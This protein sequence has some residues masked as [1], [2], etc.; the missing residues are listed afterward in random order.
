MEYRKY[1]LV[2]LFLLFLS[3]LVH[4]PIEVQKVIFKKVVIEEPVYVDVISEYRLIFVDPCRS[5]QQS[6]WYN[7][8]KLEKICNGEFV[9]AYPYVDYQYE[10][11]PLVAGVWWI[12]T[13]ISHGITVTLSLK[14]FP[15][16]TLTIFY[17]LYSFVTGLILLGAYNTLYRIYQ[18]LGA[19]KKLIYVL[20]TL[21]P[22]LLIYSIYSWTGYTLLLV[23]KFLYHV[24]E[25]SVQKALFYLGLLSSFNPLGF[26]IIFIMAYH[27]V[28][29][30]FLRIRCGKQV[31]Y[32]MAGLL[33]YVIQ[34]VLS[35]ESFI[36]IFT[37]FMWNN[38]NNCIYLLITQNHGSQ[39]NPALFVATYVIFTTI[40]LVLIPRKTIVN[41]EMSTYSYLALLLGFTISLS[42]VFTPQ[43]LLLV[44]TLLPPLYGIY[45]D[46]RPVIPHI[47]TDVCNSLIIILWFHDVEIRRSLS[48][49]G[50]RL[51]YNPFSLESPIQ[52]IAQIRNI[53]ILTMLLVLSH[54]YLELA[55][56]QEP[57]F[58]TI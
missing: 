55:K 50:L 6:I 39:I 29:G 34:G 1:T 7:E 23:L 46:Y 32:M 58:N 22:T 20:V 24:I 33:P 16:Y 31:A 13:M 36:K 30:G 38:C 11:A 49:L 47:I 10:H 3:F 25:G 5:I 8:E 40:Y 27:T 42:L 14:P 18:I 19:R 54:E 17:L 12:L 51:E 15:V 57:E 2:L 26:V 53:I 44:L 35:K 52:W 43:S 56:Y 48:I 21:S 4:M 37:W 28:A 45:K 41:E 9:L